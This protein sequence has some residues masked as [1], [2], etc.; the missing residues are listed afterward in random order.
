MRVPDL[1]A[2]GP[3]LSLELFPPRTAEAAEQLGRT[4]EQLRD[5]APAF[6]SVTYGAGGSTRAPTA[7]LVERLRRETPWES[8]PHLTGVGHTDGDVREIVARFAQAGVTNVLALRGDPP[9]DGGVAAGD[10]AHAAD[11]VRALRR[12]PASASFAIGAAAFPDGHP[13]TP[14]RLREMDYLRAKADAGVDWLCT[15]L[16]FD[17]GAFFDFAERC[18]L[19]GIRVP[20]LAGVWPVTSAAALRRM[21]DLAAGVRIPARLLREVG[22][23]QDDADAVRRIGMEFAVAQCAELFA[24]GV[25]GVHL[26]PFNRAVPVREIAAAVGWPR[27]TRA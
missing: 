17:N 1:L 21:A 11:L 24:A 25:A 27:G 13:A 6:V 16:F 2:A 5:A 19:S 26:Y 8:V 23:W 22:R 7:E 18:A 3:T 20:I 14:N 15:Q 9:R 4:L 10:F 12:D